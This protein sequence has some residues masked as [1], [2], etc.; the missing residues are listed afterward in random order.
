VKLSDNS[1]DHKAFGCQPEGL[2]GP[3]KIA[4]LLHR[5]G[6][7]A[8]LHTHRSLLQKMQFAESSGGN[9]R[10]STC[11]APFSRAYG[12]QTTKVYSGRGADIVMQSSEVLVRQR[13]TYDD[14]RLAQ[15]SCLVAQKLP[16]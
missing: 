13:C 2:A 4:L 8:V 14:S 1:A 7:T 15:L 11:S 3:D 9:L 10:L 6:S 12:R 16:N 5:C